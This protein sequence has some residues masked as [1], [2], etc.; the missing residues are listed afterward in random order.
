MSSP[1]V[2]SRCSSF[3]FPS[4]VVPGDSDK[5]LFYFQGGGACW[6]QTS[7]DAKSCTSDALPQD[8]VGLFDRSNPANPFKV[9]STWSGVA[10]GLICSRFLIVTSTGLHDCPRPLLL[11]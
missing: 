5:L 8:L 3:L 1:A 10:C 11:G 2:L 6:D 7:T 4:Q 9:T